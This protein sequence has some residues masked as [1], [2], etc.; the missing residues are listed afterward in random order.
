MKT[1]IITTVMTL[2]LLTVLQACTD[3]KGDTTI[4]KLLEPVPVRVIDPKQTAGTQ[5]IK[6]S[7]QLTT[8]DETVLGFKTSGVVR[9]ILVNE[10]DAIKKGQLLA[11]LDLREI[12][13]HVS[14]A[15]H[16]YEKTKRDLQRLENLYRDSVVTLEQLE[17]AKTALELAK[18]QLDIVKFNQGFSA[19][20]AAS[21]GFILRKFVNAGQVVDVGDPI[22]MTNG[23]ATGKWILKVVVSDKQWFKIKV[24]DR[25]KVNIDA[26]AED[27]L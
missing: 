2:A 7:G 20:H 3:S 5:T 1:N 9:S 13:A 14:Q 16:G 8:N 17:N 23:A 12:D 24:G 19:I 22:V 11:T 6:A 10:G 27:V 25:A 18:E 21:D 4:P 15:T 26:F